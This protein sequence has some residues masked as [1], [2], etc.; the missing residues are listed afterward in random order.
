MSN[1]KVSEK[2]MTISTELADLIAKQEVI[3]EFSQRF[4]RTF[5]PPKFES[6]CAEIIEEDARHLRMCESLAINFGVLGNAR[7][8]T[9]RMLEV[10][11]S[12]IFDV[13]AHPLERLGSYL[14]L[15]QDQLMCLQVL[16]KAAMTLEPD[17]KLVL[18]PV[19]AVQHEIIKNVDKVKDIVEFVGVYY[20]TGGYTESKVASIFKDL[21]GS[22]TGMVASYFAKPIEEMNITTVLTMDHKKVEVLIKQIESEVETRDEHLSQLFLDVFSHSRAEE[23]VLYPELKKIAPDSVSVDEM[24]KEHAAVRAQL[25]A[26]LNTDIKG[27]EFMTL[28]GGFK[29][30]IKHHIDDEEDKAFPELIANLE[31][32]QLQLLSQQFKLSKARI[33]A[34]V[35]DVAGLVKIKA[36]DRALDLD[37]LQKAG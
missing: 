37:S 24:F 12:V 34:E 32:A 23:E 25:E 4:L 2:R 13:A 17:I 9:E 22:V 30:L 27:D 26:L 6:V 10:S 1:L 31:D 33:Q 15:K 35:F 28:F 8:A 19:E 14:L 5:C 29:D 3:S 11:R 21:M 36:A 18:A 7:G 16:H 20:V